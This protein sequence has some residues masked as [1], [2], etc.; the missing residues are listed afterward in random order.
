M[1]GRKWSKVVAMPHWGPV[2][3]YISSNKALSLSLACY[4]YLIYVL[5]CWKGTISKTPSRWRRYFHYDRQKWR[6][7]ETMTETPP[8]ISVHQK[9]LLTKF[10]WKTIQEDLRR[11][12]DYLIPASFIVFS[13]KQPAG[14]YNPLSGACPVHMNGHGT[15]LLCSGVLCGRRLF[16]KLSKKDRVDEVLF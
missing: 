3:M 9:Q 14:V 16:F 11:A 7:L 6:L 4:T 10:C 12:A 13:S 5:G 8:F 15:S 2:H 1:I